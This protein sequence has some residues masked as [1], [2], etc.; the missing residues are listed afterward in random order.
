MKIKYRYGTIRFW[1][2]ILCTM[3][4]F[5]V[6]L[7]QFY[8]GHNNIV[9][10]LYFF[11]IACGGVFG[12]F[13]SSHVSKRQFVLLSYY[14]YMIINIITR[15][16][17]FPSDVILEGVFDYIFTTM[18]F[19]FALYVGKTKEIDPLVN[20]ILI[21]ACISAVLGI[22]EF[23]TG[24]TFLGNQNYTFEN[25]IAVKRSS[26]LLDASLSYG[27]VEAISCAAAFA[28]YRTSDKRLYLY[29]FILCMLGTFSAFSR[30]PMVSLAVTIVICFV[31]TRDNNKHTF[32]PKTVVIGVVVIA[33]VVFVVDKI[34]TN[35]VMLGRLASIT[36]WTTDKG[37]VA[38]TVKWR[39]YLGY[40][41]DNPLFGIGP[42][43]AAISP[44]GVAESGVI[45]RLAET[46]SIGMLLYYGFLIP[47]MVVGIRKLK[48]SSNKKPLLC[49][50]CMVF[51]VLVEDCIL[52]IF[53]STMVSYLLWFGLALIEISIR[54]DEGEERN[55]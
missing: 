5:S 7:W 30:G 18:V 39:I 29:A 31:L 38:R 54:K 45:K 48:G 33:I 4:I 23:G 15:I 36:N 34:D 27:C 40:F 20:T 19:W 25:G 13:S 55:A 50:I 16:G 14:V 41:A 10:S 1:V 43:Y 12:I 32:N 21:F 24:I 22:L 2:F 17:T 37:N 11:I 52:Q 26:G 53:V 42:N 35:N 3:Y 47:E 49:G 44:Y 9:R 51:V 46:G 8:F 28:L 6:K